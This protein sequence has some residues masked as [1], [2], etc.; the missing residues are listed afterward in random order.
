MYKEERTFG[1][2]LCAISGAVGVWSIVTEGSSGV[3]WLALAAGLLG[4]ALVVPR[5]Y[6][7]LLKIWLKIGHVVAWV[8]TRLILGLVFLLLI[9]PI[10]LARRI[11]GY[12]S[13]GIRGKRKSSYWIDRGDE[14]SVE[15]YRKQY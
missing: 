1:L 4:V 8:N 5:C 7:P 11:L 6:S 15:S 2:I 14:W 13:M 3:Y 12:D 10:A 9:I